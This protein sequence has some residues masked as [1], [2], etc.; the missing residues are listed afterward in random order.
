M[1]DTPKF[2]VVDRRKMKADEEKES[3]RSCEQ[4]APPEKP[5]ARIG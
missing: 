4:P 3:G 2:E 5:R 1:S